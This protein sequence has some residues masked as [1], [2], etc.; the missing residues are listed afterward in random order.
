MIVIYFFVIIISLIIWKILYN[1][2]LNVSYIKSDCDQNYYLIRN[3]GSDCS[4]KKAVNLLASVRKDLIYFCIDLKKKR[5]T[6]R[7][8]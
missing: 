1:K 7:R 8:N 5:R 3:D 4:K 6:S 2:R